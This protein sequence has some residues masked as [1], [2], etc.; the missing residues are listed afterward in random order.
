MELRRTDSLDLNFETGV[1]IKVD[2]SSVEMSDE[3]RQAVERLAERSTKF[4]VAE[5]VDD[6]CPAQEV[7]D[8]RDFELVRRLK[9]TL[10]AGTVAAPGPIVDFCLHVIVVGS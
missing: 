3:Q 1:A 4:D 9:A 8:E 5:C 10:G 7:L 6:R 2:L